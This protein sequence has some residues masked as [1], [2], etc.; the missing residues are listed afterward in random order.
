MV[1]VMIMVTSFKRSHACFAELRA[2]NPAAGH[3]L[4]TAP[5]ETPGHSWA[6]LGQSLVESLFFLLGPGGHKVFFVPSNIL[7]QQS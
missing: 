6:C 3:H 5:P 7:F 4:P 2:P 1:E